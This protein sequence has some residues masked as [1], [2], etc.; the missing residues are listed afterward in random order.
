MRS[1]RYVVSCHYFPEQFWYYTIPDCTNRT[2]SLLGDP[3]AV[4]NYFAGIA[5]T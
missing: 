5:G 3:E 1:T 2:P 4:N